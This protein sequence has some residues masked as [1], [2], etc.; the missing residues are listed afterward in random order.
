MDNHQLTVYFLDS[1]PDH[2][3]R[4]VASCTLTPWLL[5]FDC[6][7]RMAKSVTVALLPRL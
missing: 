1:L 6:I 5:S 2:D 3:G 4:G 7:R